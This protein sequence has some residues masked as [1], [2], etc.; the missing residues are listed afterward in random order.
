MPCV[1]SG[2]ASSYMNR[3][4]RSVS[5]DLGYVFDTFGTAVS[6]ETACCEKDSMRYDVFYSK[7][8]F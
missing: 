5:Y 2:T 8:V 7:I 6:L 3:V 4:G 1:T